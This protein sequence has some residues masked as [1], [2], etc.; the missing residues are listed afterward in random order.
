MRAQHERARVLVDQGA[1]TEANEVLER[2]RAE[3]SQLSQ[4]PP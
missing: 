2:I 4:E 1:L 3:W